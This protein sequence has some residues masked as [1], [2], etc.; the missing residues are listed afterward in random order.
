MARPF[1]LVAVKS[2]LKLWALK[3]NMFRHR[4]YNQ[5][6]GGRWLHTLVAEQFDA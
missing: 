3:T 6:D 1:E 4:C 2:P 5:D